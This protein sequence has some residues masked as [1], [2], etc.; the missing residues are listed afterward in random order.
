MGQTKQTFWSKTY[1]FLKVKPTRQD[2]TVYKLY[3]SISIETNYYEFL[4]EFRIITENFSFNMN[5]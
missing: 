5:L 4:L 3:S 1:Q 2:N